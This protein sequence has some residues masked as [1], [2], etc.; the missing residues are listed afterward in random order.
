MTA[1]HY[2]CMRGN[3]RI[4]DIIID[5]AELYH[6]DLEAKDKFG[7]NGAKI[8]EYYKKASVVNLIREKMPA[9]F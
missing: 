7:R 4:V 1:F 8:A 9:L 2:A 6:I 5:N 3:T